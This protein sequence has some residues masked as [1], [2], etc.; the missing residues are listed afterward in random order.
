M[1][2]NAVIREKVIENSACSVTPMEKNRVFYTE[3]LIL[4]LT[5]SY[6]DWKIGFRCRRE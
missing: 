4:F 3:E 6:T 1:A 5:I 2:K